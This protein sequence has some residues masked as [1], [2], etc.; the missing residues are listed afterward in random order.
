MGI[1][2]VDLASYTPDEEALAL[3]P[4]AVARFRGVLP[5]FEIEGMLTVAM[6][7]PSTSSRWMSSRSI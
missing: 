1:P 6:A 7:T 3:V 2:R 4:A 5:L